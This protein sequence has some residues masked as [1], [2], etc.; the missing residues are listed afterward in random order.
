MVIDKTAFYFTIF[1][2]TFNRKHLLPRVYNSLRK[3]TYTDFEWLI[4]DD[5]S[6]DATSELVKAWQKENR[7]PLRYYFQEN[8]GKHIAWNKAADLARGEYFLCADSDDEFVPESLETFRNCLESMPAHQRE[9]YFGAS[10]LCKTPTGDIVGERYP[11]NVSASSFLELFFHYKIKGEK[12]NCGRTAVHREVRFEEEFKRSCL[13]ESTV[14]F[15]IGETYK[16]LLLNRPL[17][18]YHA[19]ADSIC[20]T[21]SFY[22]NY[23]GMLLWSRQLLNDHLKTY[24]KSSLPFFVD[25]AT[26]YSRSCFH[27][28]IPIIQQFK[29]L[30]N[31]PAKFIWASMLPRGLALYFYDNYR[32]A[33]LKP[34]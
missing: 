22:K 31:I 11:S 25:Y 5:G 32:K 13:P 24:W 8:Q 10:A 33:R 9:Q 18:I 14:W 17:R 1:T 28:G 3:Q 6:T 34:D 29:N 15:K 26:A 2:P 12:W 21:S 27:S 30:H 23:P 20:H 19:E 16:V 7:F 4:V